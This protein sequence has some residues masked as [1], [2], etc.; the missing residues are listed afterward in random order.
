MAALN[1]QQVKVEQAFSTADDF[2]ALMEDL[3]D[4]KTPKSEN[5]D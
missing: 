1:E 2:D 4:D 5:R 3:M